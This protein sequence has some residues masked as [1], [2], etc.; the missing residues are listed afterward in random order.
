[1]AKE[2]IDATL[3][4]SLSSSIYYTG[5]KWPG[6]FLYI[7]LNDDPIVYL[8]I[9]DE[10]GFA[11]RSWIQNL[12][13]YTDYQGL[14]E[15]LRVSFNRTRAKIIGLEF[16]LER[17]SYMYFYNI[18]KQN[19]GEVNYADISQHILDQRM[20]KDRFELNAVKRAGSIAK[21]SIDKALSMVK[22]GVSETEI[23]GEILSTLY[24]LGSIEPII[25]VNIGPDNRTF[26]EPF[27]EI[28][29]KDGVSVTVEIMADYNRIY[30]ETSRTL[31]VGS[32]NGKIR[33]AY[34][35]LDR[36]YYKAIQAI[37]E[38]KRTRNV[39]ETISKLFYEEGF[40]ITSTPLHGIGYQP[41][42]KPYVEAYSQDNEI[43]IQPKMSIVSIHSPIIVKGIGKFK[44]E[45][46]FLVN[47]DGYLENVT[48]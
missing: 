46:T 37:M 24:K 19:I 3:I 30:A 11:K 41:I 23:V 4:S 12:E 32:H 22:P 25:H 16:S 31:Y 33:R 48:I 17:E 27:N 8:P 43:I 18:L 28:R 36:A 47:E 13:T 1:M 6:L 45:D 7:P 38:Q 21:R 9:G 2:G 40:Q 20:I 14:V 5:I 35:L 39:I 10:E 34:N 42:E 44:K 29:V 15:K 26:A